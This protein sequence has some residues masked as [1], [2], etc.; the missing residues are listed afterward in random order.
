M[1]PATARV[2]TAAEHRVVARRGRRSSSGPVTVR[3]VLPSGVDM[4]IEDQ[5]V[6]RFRAR[7]GTVVPKSVGS[8]V[9]RNRVRRQLRHLLAERLPSL[10]PGAAV[11]VR[12]AASPSLPGPWAELAADLDRAWAGATAVRER[13]PHG[14]LA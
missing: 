1:L 7:A 12:V 5:G 10:P 14:R 3:I 4:A 11:V 9:R 13:R 2:R 8:A 6:G